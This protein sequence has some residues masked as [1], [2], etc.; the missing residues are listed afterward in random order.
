M[1]E[2]A[3]CAFADD[4][5]RGMLVPRDDVERDVEVCAAVEVDT[6]HLVVLDRVARDLG[7]A[8]A[9]DHAVVAV[10]GDA[11]AGD[12]DVV[13]DFDHDAAVVDAALLARAANGAPA[14]FRLVGHAHH[15]PASSAIDDDGLRVLTAKGDTG[16][17]LH[18][19][20]VNARF[21]DN[22]RTRRRMGERL[23]DRSVIPRAGCGNRDRVR[24]LGADL[25]GHGDDL[26]DEIAE[27][28]GGVEL[29]RQRPAITRQYLKRGKRRPP[30]LHRVQKDRDEARLPLFREVERTPHLP[31]LQ[32]RFQV[33]VT[34]LDQ[35]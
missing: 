14:D 25:L 4:V 31:P 16:P 6:Q 26:R 17:H 19:L 18:V 5:Q 3:F 27:R 33:D 9:Q 1:T 28:V 24:P 7:A 21:H 23:A 20:R 10:V 34:D 2:R 15:P 32:H 29:R 22:H 8:S 30:P 13:A 35:E 12:D 11:V